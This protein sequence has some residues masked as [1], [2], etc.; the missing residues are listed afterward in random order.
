MAT[1]PAARRRPA[2]AAVP[3]VL[4]GGQRPAVPEPVA[5]VPPVAEPT[6]PGPA[7][8]LRRPRNVLVAGLVLGVLLG[9][10]GA[11]YVLS[12]HAVYRSS[13]VL[14]LDQEPALAKSE[15]DALLSKLVRLRLKYVDIVST[16]V[17][18][19][20]VAKALGRPVGEVHGALSATAA[21][22]S[23]LLTI[24]AQAGSADAAREIAQ[25]AADELVTYL[26]DEEVAARIPEDNRVT[27]TVVSAAPQGTKAS[28]SGR[29][30]LLAAVFLFAVVAAA[31]ALAADALR[32]KDR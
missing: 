14:M 4:A 27:L 20:P 8:R 6:V 11:G 15:N 9:G 29:R 22:T 28:P 18:A 30:A 21:P 10:I 24:Q 16:T 13:A 5:V 32:R 3:T 26:Q 17:F 25:G 2:A 31:G 1:K 12:R 7:R 19:D 23:L